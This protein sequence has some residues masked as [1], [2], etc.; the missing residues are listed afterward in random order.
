VAQAA[1]QVGQ[2][3]NAG[4]AE[5]EMLESLFDADPASE[6][7][8]RRLL[9]LLNRQGDHRRARAVVDLCNTSRSLELEAPLAPHFAPARHLTEGPR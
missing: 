3:L 6:P 9:E 1:L 5:L 2:E 7:I 8:A 4:E